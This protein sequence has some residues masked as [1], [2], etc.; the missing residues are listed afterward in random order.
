MTTRGFT[1]ASTSEFLG[2][3]VTPPPALI[4]DPNTEGQSRKIVV[5]SNQY[6]NAESKRNVML[7]LVTKKVLP[8]IDDE[9]GPKDTF[10]TNSES[11]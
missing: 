2:T 10:G 8:P 1:L 9:K 4:H 6:V 5:E 7:D 11:S 3:T